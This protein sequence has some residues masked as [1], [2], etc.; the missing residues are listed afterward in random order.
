MNSAK[1][2]HLLLDLKAIGRIRNTSN[3][4]SDQKK[5]MFMAIVLIVF[6]L[7]MINQAG[8]VVAVPSLFMCTYADSQTAN[9]GRLLFIQNMG[10]AQELQ[11]KSQRGVLF[12][13]VSD[14]NNTTAISKKNNNVVMNKTNTDA[15]DN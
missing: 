10:A 4:I 7:S 6:Y 3:K 15:N 5:K 13:L 12:L 14:A 8:I 9:S 2:I 1:L 11:Q